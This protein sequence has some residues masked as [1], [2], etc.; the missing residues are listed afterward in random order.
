[1][2]AAFPGTLDQLADLLG[3]AATAFEVFGHDTEGQYCRM[4]KLCHP[5]L[6][7]PGAEQDK[8]TKVFRRLTELRDAAMQ[9]A[10][11]RVV[12]S[13][14][15]QYGLVKQ[16]AA[17]D[18][19]DVH[20]AVADGVRYVVKITRPAGG[21]PLMAAEARHLKLLTTRCGDRRYREY[22]PNL[23]E[24]FAAPGTGGD[25]QA[26]VFVYREGFY[27]LEELRRKHTAG[28]DGRHLAWIF[29]RMLIV[30]VFAFV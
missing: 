17:G 5:D 12:H 24:T 30:T 25:R 10:T 28:L 7:P 29:K 20:L 11:P 22:L 26:N 18:L 21:N 6:F 4:A 23:V 3:R 2:S 8:A 14:T 13:P 15:R 9:A 1:M 16:L 27:T 19:A